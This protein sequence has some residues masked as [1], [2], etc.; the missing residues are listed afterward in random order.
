MAVIILT[1]NF[2]FIIYLE[3]GKLNKYSEILW[4]YYEHY[5]WVDDFLDTQNTIYF[6]TTLNIKSNIAN[7]NKTIT[8]SG[9]NQIQ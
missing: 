7:S 9:K 3:R 5:K 4:F 8:Q 6:I 2:K 1:N